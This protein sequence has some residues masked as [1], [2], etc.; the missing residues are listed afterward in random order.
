MVVSQG[1]CFYLYSAAGQLDHLQKLEAG[2]RDREVGRERSKRKRGEKKKRWDRDMNRCCKK[3]RECGEDEQKGERE[4]GIVVE[5]GREGQWQGHSGLRE[6]G[7]VRQGRVCLR[8]HKIA[9]P[10]C[11]CTMVTIY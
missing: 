4:K 7:R 5:S 11:M 6:R 1:I 10:K 3:D 8:E 9:R 2:R